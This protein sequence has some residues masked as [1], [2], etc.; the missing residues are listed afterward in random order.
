MVG[1]AGPATDTCLLLHPDS[2]APPG[3]GESIGK[4]LNPATCASRD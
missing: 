3:A 4:D 1:E 2:L